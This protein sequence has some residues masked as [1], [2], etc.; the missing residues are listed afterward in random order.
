MHVYP[1]M[2]FILNEI[3]FYLFGTQ[4]RLRRLCIVCVFLARNCRWKQHMLHAEQFTAATP[5]GD[6][7]QRECTE[8]VDIGTAAVASIY[9]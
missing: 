7:R 2:C 6:C 1:S 9:H 4:C 8:T 5:G 3:C